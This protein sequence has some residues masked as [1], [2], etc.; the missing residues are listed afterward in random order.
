[1]RTSEIK[2]CIFFFWM[3]GSFE[4]ARDSREKPEPWKVLVESPNLG[5]RKRLFPI[6]C[7]LNVLCPSTFHFYV[8]ILMYKVLVLD[9]AF[10]RWCG[11]SAVIKGSCQPCQGTVRRHH[12]QQGSRRS[13]HT[14]PVGS[15]ILDFRIRDYKK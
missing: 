7:G 3:R 8:E 12:C 15:V 2:R 9:G 6:C 1:M 5:K 14:E 13:P 10:W 4:V 11:I